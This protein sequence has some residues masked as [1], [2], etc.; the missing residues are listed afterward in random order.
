MSRSAMQ[1]LTERRPFEAADWTRFDFYARRI[2]ILVVEYFDGDGPPHRSQA[3]LNKLHAI[4]GAP[5][6]PNLRSATW[7]ITVAKPT[8][9]VAFVTC[10]APSSL[11]EIS[12]AL[13]SWQLM[14]NLSV[15]LHAFARSFP[16]IQR[17]AF[18]TGPEVDL[19][20][21][22]GMVKHW[23]EL[24]GF[25]LG[26]MAIQLRDGFVTIMDYHLLDVL[27]KL[28]KLNDLQIDT[29]IG[30]NKTR[31]S[32]REAFPDRPFLFRTLRRLSA[33]SR[34]SRNANVVQT[35]L[36]DILPP[37][38]QEL[39]VLT[40]DYSVF[41]DLPAML[42]TCTFSCK[43][44]KLDISMYPWGIG[45][46]DAFVVPAS[47]LFPIV[48]LHGLRQLTL[49]LVE[50]A[51]GFVFD[52]GDDDWAVFASSWP[53]LRDLSVTDGTGLSGRTNIRST[54]QTLAHLAQHCPELSSVTLTLLDTADAP[55]HLK[56]DTLHVH[57]C[58]QRLRLQYSVIDDL[59]GFASRIAQIFPR[60]TAITRMAI[61][62]N[63]TPW[64]RRQ[65]TDLFE[66]CTWEELMQLVKRYREQDTARG[67]CVVTSSSI[68]D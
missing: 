43:L 58:L 53:S 21:L 3:L 49:R 31:L 12:V 67:G 23:R 56:S 4:K 61:P 60:L 45:L 13:G 7:Q 48:H 22:A 52:V 9:L 6:L 64:E 41:T 50:G 42:Q 2:R 51:G 47:D 18:N 68:A 57:T 59:A 16:A 14:Q 25:R 40:T 11:T 15:D 20:I 32:A 38:L 63:P 66:E 17:A 39:D 26:I 24:R 19:A 35:L 46:D 8:N 36:K 62:E 10:I 5:L 44:R 28:P 34:H 27:S 54:F 30:S 55:S 37:S 1:V 33:N 65:D 29:M